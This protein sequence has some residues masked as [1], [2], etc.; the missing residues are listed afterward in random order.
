MMER[1]NFNSIDEYI[2]SFPEDMQELLQQVRTT[3]RNAAPNATERISYG[4][5]TFFLNGNLVHFGGYKSHVGFYPGA[6]GIEV[7]KDRLSSY[8][9][10]RGTVRFPSDKPIPFDLIKEITEFRVNQNLGKKKLKKEKS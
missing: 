2:A 9:L 8:P 3:I 4:I 5:P 6:E 10:S 7:F 1:Q